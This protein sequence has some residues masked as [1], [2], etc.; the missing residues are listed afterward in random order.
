M[1]R[2]TVRINKNNL[3]YS[4]KKKLTVKVKTAKHSNVEGCC[5]SNGVL[6]MEAT[7]KSITEVENAHHVMEPF[8]NLIPQREAK[9]P[10]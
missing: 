9:S 10:R 2:A 6:C 1:E 8:D 7:N 4:S 3:D 5:L